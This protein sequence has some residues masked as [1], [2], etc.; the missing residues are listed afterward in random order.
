[1]ISVEEKLIPVNKRFADEY[2]LDKVLKILGNPES[3]LPTVN[4]VGTNG[5]GSTS[6]YLSKGLLKKYKKVGLFISPAFLYQNER[7][8]I[9]NDYISDQDLKDYL[10]RVDRYI[11]EYSLTFFEIWTLIA[12]MYFSDNN[13]D[14]VVME[15]GIG[16]VN[17]CTSLM[18]NQILSLVTSISFDHVDVLGADINGIIDQ[19]VNIVK[20]NSTIIISED[21]LKYIDQVKKSLETKNVE[22][23]QA[24]RLT[25]SVYYQE[26][27]KGLA[28]KALEFLD[29]DIDKELFKL[30]PPLGRFTTIIDGERRIVI[31]GAHNE[32]GINK[33]I[34]TVNNQEED[35][36]ILFGSITTKDYDLN[37]QNLNKNFDEV[38][39]TNF[40]HFKA[41][42]INEI[43]YSKKVVDWREFIRNNHDRNILVCGSLYFIPLVYDWLLRK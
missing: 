12:I 21:N 16:G 42:D 41:W 37:L 26:G 24:Q 15:A 43:E 20:P 30:Q 32:D 25:D 29:V 17:D 6:F 2:N 9:N 27:N 19:K 34:E 1:M 35:Y 39:I 33:L 23:I 7:I 4:I 11:N 38:Y 13:V 36:I 22:I 28:K 14:I 10:S 8:Q 31:D 18:S 40:E 5:K 3:K